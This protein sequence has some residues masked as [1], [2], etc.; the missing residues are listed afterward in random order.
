VKSQNLTYLAKVD[1]KFYT[2]SDYNCNKNESTCFN[3]PSNVRMLGVAYDP[4][5][6]YVQVGE[7]QILDSKGLSLRDSIIFFK[8]DFNNCQATYIKSIVSHEITTIG[9]LFYIDY[10]GQYYLDALAKKF[11][12]NLYGMFRTDSDTFKLLK[13]TNY[14]AN[15][16]LFIDNIILS[17]DWYNK[18]IITCDTNF[19]ALKF[20][21]FPDSVR[22][23]HNLTLLHIDCDSSVVLLSGVLAT[24]QEINTMGASAPTGSIIYH[25]DYKNNKLINPICTLF[26]N[27]PRAWGLTSLSSDSEFLAS[28]PE[29]DLLIDLDRNNSTGLLP[30]DY[31][32]NTNTCYDFDSVPICDLDVYIH[33]SFPLD[34]IRLCIHDRRNSIDEKL[35]TK[36]LLS[37]FQ[38]IQR[39]DSCW[40]ISKSGASDLEYS[41]ALKEIFYYNHSTQIVSGLRKISI[42]G[43]NSLK[44]G[45]VVYAYLTIGKKVFAG[46]D[47]RITVCDTTLDFSMFDHLGIGI[48]TNGLWM[49]GGLPY[50]QK[51]SSLNMNYGTYQYIVQ[52]LYCNSDTAFL[53]I[54]KTKGMRF[55]FGPDQMIC[56]GDSLLYSIKDTSPF[57]KIVLNGKEI[58]SPFKIYSTG[59]YII[60]L[61]SKDGCSFSD[62]LNVKKSNQFYIQNLNQ[63]LCSNE[64]LKYK[65]NL[66][67]AGETIQDTI[68]PTI[69]CDTIKKIYLEEVLNP[70]IKATI[71]ICADQAHEYKNK[72]YP[73]GS[74]IFDT[75]RSL[76][77][78]DT[79]LELNIIAFP[80]EKINLKADTII[81]KNETVE[82]QANT[83]F[84]SYK[85]STGEDKSSIQVG[86]GTYTLTVTDVNGCNVNSSITIKESPPIQYSAI[87]MDPLCPE[88]KG[89]IEITNLQGGT[90]PLEYYL[91][92]KKVSLSALDYLNSGI[93]IFK[94]IDSENCEVSDTIQILDAAIF[95]VVFDDQIELEEGESHSLTFP[96][97]NPKIASIQVSPNSDVV[98]QNGTELKFS[99]KEDITYTITFT[100]ERGCELIKT[101][102]FTIKRN[103]GFY[104]PTIFSPNGDNI[105]D[106][107]QPT[108]GNV[109]TLVSATIFDRWGEQ[110]YYTNNPSVEW[111]GT[112]KS[113]QCNPGVYVYLIELRHRDGSVKKFSGDVGLIR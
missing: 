36:S 55:D 3:F 20:N 76:V 105:N 47:K 64:K 70:N 86:S 54:Q 100:D 19:N 99:P 49:P 106:T 94:A 32:D 92:G 6:Y 37:G 82:I 38:F 5:G 21:D 75:L 80:Q 72:S 78:C 84:Q 29:C 15:D 95:D 28:D 26:E 41:Q 18:K 59:Q 89:S 91:N 68:S 112:Y 34:S 48:D 43:F 107:W 44:S 101:I 73:S 14:Y 56:N 81:C 45:T 8:L 16:I 40:I 103:E 93:Y 51:F 74:I 110:V 39:T 85:W 52:D 25:Y 67:G 10:K 13:L 96:N 65:N 79:F 33:T 108:Y 69:G 77:S 22:A 87:P 4:A 30:Y 109:Y 57:Q 50:K 113:Q 98:I 111:N 9:S 23:F 66:Y 27:T 102:T 12:T 90:A 63:Q 2:H 46:K 7:I 1:P 104:P 62:T 24:Y 42:Q 11:P 88:D 58:S 35:Y 60:N 17:I 61:Q 31:K 83:N 97:Q 71:E 53:E